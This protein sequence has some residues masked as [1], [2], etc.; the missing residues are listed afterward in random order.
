MEKRFKNKEHKI[1]IGCSDGST[2]SIDALEA[3]D[4]AGYTNIVGLRG[5][6][7]AW[8]DRWDNKLRRRTNGEAVEVYSADGDS[9]GIHSSGAG[10][11]R[12]DVIGKIKWPKDE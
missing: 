4:E 11:E 6:Y 7:Y 5:G 8:H 9:C 12:V 10:F 3:L 2:Y 1:L